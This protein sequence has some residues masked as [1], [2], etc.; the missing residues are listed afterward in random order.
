LNV[1]QIFC[2]D[3]QRFMKFPGGNSWII[4]GGKF[5]RLI[6][7]IPLFTRPFSCHSHSFVLNG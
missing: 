5:P 7:G 4:S 6:S 2:S 3:Y 1:A